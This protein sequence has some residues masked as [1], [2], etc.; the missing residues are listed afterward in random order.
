MTFSW[1]NSEGPPPKRWVSYKLSRVCKFFFKKG[2]DLLF[3]FSV[4]SGCGVTNL[5]IFCGGHKYMTP[6][7]FKIT[8]NSVITGGSSFL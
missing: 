8:T 6:K 7:W 5:L 4:F 3:I 2:N 1:K